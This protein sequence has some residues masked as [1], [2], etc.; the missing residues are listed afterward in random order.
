ME[1]KKTVHVTDATVA[2]FENK[3]HACPACKHKPASKVIT[4]TSIPSPNPNNLKAQITC[5]L[6]LCDGCFALLK[7]KIS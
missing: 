6:H 2:Q 3:G 1:D 4:F 5:V 7:S